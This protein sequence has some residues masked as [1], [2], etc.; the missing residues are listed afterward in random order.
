M[1]IV[2]VGGGQLGVGI[3]A[4]LS[5]EGHELSLIE[6]SP[7]VAERLGAAYEIMAFNGNGVRRALQEKAG[8]P[9]ADILIAVS[10]SDEVNML[11]CLTARKL[12]TL[13]T[14]A[15][16]REPEYTEQAEFLSDEM[17]LSLYVNPEQS[18]AEEIAS[19]IKSPGAQQIESFAD[20]Q[21]QIAQI[22][23]KEH[24]RLDGVKLS[25]F[26]NLTDAKVLAC[27][28]KRGGDVVIPDGNFVLRSGDRVSFAANPDEMNKLFKYLGRTYEPV[29]KVMIVGGGRVSYYL[30]ELLRSAKISVTVM[31]RDAAAC[32]LLAAEFPDIRVLN[33]DGTDQEFQREE[34]IWSYDAVAALTNDDEDN[35]IIAMY[36]ESIGIKRIVAK[37][38]RE[39]LP[40]IAERVF[41]GTIISPKLTAAN[42]I[43]QYVRAMTGS[44]GGN[45]E[46]LHKI[47]GGKVE[48]LEFSAWRESKVIGV[49]LKDLKIKKGILIASIV[50]GEYSGDAG[51]II[52]GGN[53]VIR[54][55]DNVIVV[56]A[57]HTLSGLDDIIGK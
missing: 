1:K 19:V 22:T 52:P 47:V 13:H 44:P 7:E 35:L 23:L 40:P 10:E 26:R 8:A 9:N 53:D 51:T 25:D 36:A 32:E 49:P 39:T 16:V 15:R 24:S 20:G 55:D 48:A 17:G 34:S 6:Q 56:T 33:G 2:I 46:T 30:I 3:I 57:S 4:A 38:E 18:A 31:E 21:L 11:C 27:A 54:A 28:V 42:Q 14:I 50:R 29:K 5:K 41:S 45:I 37:L 43:V 12:G